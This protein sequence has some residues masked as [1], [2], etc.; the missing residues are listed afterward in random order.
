MDLT[1]VSFPDMNTATVAYPNQ[2]VASHLGTAGRCIESKS[3]K[4]KIIN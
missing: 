4:I 3:I 1:V 2:T